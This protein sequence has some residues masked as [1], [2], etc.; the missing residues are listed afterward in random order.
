MKYYF[1]ILTFVSTSAI[2]VACR[3]LSLLEKEK[4]ITTSC[5]FDFFSSFCYTFSKSAHLNNWQSYKAYRNLAL[6]IPFNIGFNYS[7][8]L[9]SLI[10]LTVLVLVIYFYSYKNEIFISNLKLEM[11]LSMKESWILESTYF[12]LICT[13]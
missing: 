6:L 9:F 7:I 13:Y 3:R 1:F 4:K 11:K 10:S 12:N 5:V 8:L 2:T